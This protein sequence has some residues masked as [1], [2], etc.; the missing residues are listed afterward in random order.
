MIDDSGSPLGWPSPVRHSILALVAAFVMLPLLITVIGGFKELGELRTNPFGLPTVWQWENYRQILGNSRYWQMLGNS[1]IIAAA[2]TVLTVGCSATAAFVFAQLKFFGSEFLLSYLSLG[3]M[4]PVATA[5]LPI[6]IAVRDMGLLDTHWAVILPQTAFG[7]AMSV[8]LCRNFFK[9][10]PLELRDAS[11]IDGTGYFG[12]FWYIV[13]PLCRPILATTGVIAFVHSWNAF[14]LPLIVLNDP[15]LYPWPLGVMT[16]QGEYSVEWNL[17]LAYI[18]L[19]MLPV[20]ILF[21][22]A[23]RYIVAGLTSG[24]VKG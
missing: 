11:F 6:F 10:L 8:L 15:G 3:L 5:V 22:A 23:Q 9:G 7:L 21:F 4:F 14:L 18:T 2:T 1:L 20:M 17:I 16:Y 12:F 13:L 19:T 24:A